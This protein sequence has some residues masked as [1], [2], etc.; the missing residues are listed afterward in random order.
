MQK[1]K[2]KKVIKTVSGI[3]LKLKKYILKLNAFDGQQKK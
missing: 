1:F 2:Y 3:P